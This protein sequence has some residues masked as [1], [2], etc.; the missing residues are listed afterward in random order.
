M[1]KRLPVE[2]ERISQPTAAPWLR[3]G[4]PGGANAV[5]DLGGGTFDISI[6]K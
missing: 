4:N 5:Y 3:I 1:R 6:G 2:V